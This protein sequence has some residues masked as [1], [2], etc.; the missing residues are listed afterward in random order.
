MSHAYDLILGGLI[1]S[2]GAFLMSFTLPV[3]VF[4]HSSGVSFEQKVGAYLVDIG[5]DPE[6]LVT[7][8]TQVFDFS[9]KKNGQ[10]VEVASIWTRILWGEKTYLATGVNVPD[11]GKPTLLFTFQNP[12]A[13]S[14]EASFRSQSG[15][16]LVKTSF[17]ISVVL[18]GTNEGREPLLLYSL[19]LMVGVGSGYLARHLR[20]V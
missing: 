12:G 15:G 18:D 7:G 17:P 5:Y 3:G 19:L 10:A 4:A 9:L 11:L 1:L 6:A 20:Q 2:T 16:E 13:Y 8:A 14:L